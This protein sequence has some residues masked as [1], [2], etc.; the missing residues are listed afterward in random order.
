MKGATSSS[1]LWGFFAPAQ[2][3]IAEESLLFE[4]SSYKVPPAYPNFY[5]LDTPAFGKINSPVRYAFV[6]YKPKP[7]NLPKSSLLIPTRF[8]KRT[9]GL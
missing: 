4:I 6:L 2:K 3:R 9:A 5:W 7:S 8:P 1:I